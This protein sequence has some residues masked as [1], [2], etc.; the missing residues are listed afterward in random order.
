MTSAVIMTV[1]IELTGPNSGG[2]LGAGLG[3][4][5]SHVQWMLVGIGNGAEMKT[6]GGAL[7]RKQAASSLRPRSILSEASYPT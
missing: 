4:L 3:P 1:I 2:E 5:A 6:G 7:G